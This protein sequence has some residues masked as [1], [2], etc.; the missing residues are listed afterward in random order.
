M[1]RRD[2]A[3]SHPTRPAS[4]PAADRAPAIA[5][6][7]SPA[8]PLLIAALALGFAL[9]VAASAIPP[10]G[11]WGLDTLRHLPPIAAV[12]IVLLAA[13]GFAPPLARAIERRLDALGAAWE[14]AGARGDLAVAIAAGLTLFFMRD[15]VRFTGDFE[16][17]LSQLAQAAP[18]AVIF[19]QASPLDRLVNVGLTRLVMSLGAEP[20]IAL[21]ATGALMGALFA[22]A[23]L[24]LIRA[25][26]ASRAMLP[27]AAAVVLG[28]G[29]MLHFAGYDK[30]GPLLVGIALGCAGAVRL[31]RDGRGAW[32]LGAGSA[33][34]VLAHRSGYA[35]LPAAAVVF[36][37]AL[38]GAGDQRARLHLFAAAALVAASAAAVLTQAVHLLRTLDRATHLAGATVSGGATPLI[39]AL[40]LVNL[41]GFVAP[42]WLAGA[43]AAWLVRPGPTPAPAPS[44]FS[45]APAA[46]LAIG[47]ELA[48][49]AVIRGRQGAARDWDMHTGAGL[50]V[51]LASAAALVAAWRRHGA[52]GALAPALTT[53]LASSLALWAIHTTPAAALSRIED[54][55]SRR[56]AWTDA[57]WARAHDFL[58]L[59]ALREHRTTDAIRALSAAVRVA[60]NPRYLFELGLAELEAGDDS[61]A[62]RAFERA[63]ARNRRFPDAWMGLAIVAYGAGDY[64]RAL[65][66]ADSGL[67]YS[68]GRADIRTV[69]DRALDAIAGRARGISGS[70]R[71]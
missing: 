70:I 24:A 29:Y 44:R 60:P 13:A 28:G 20:E 23:S 30:F 15:T 45:L 9:R 32:Q 39:H 3:P 58:G 31:A 7:P 53:A 18:M 34:C 19:P 63:V 21:Q 33:I 57:T 12:A 69:R 2:L 55:L 8:P 11:L 71:E 4:R 48:L 54:A 37:R 59:R 22:M 68:P 66:C 42:L 51:T 25:A 62:L 50:I 38:R 67:S 35:L 17:R 40:D 27:A 36:V 5:E 52:R 41:L 46:W 14:R 65:A 61:L 16:T 43:A 49:V 56:A 64:T 47:A 10:A 1:R 26:G 6:P